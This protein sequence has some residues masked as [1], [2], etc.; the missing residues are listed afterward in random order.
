MLDIRIHM[1]YLLK[2]LYI[3]QRRENDEGNHEYA[4]DYNY[5]HLGPGPGGGGG[6]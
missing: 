2:S 4:I 1:C 5:H 3:D 6:P